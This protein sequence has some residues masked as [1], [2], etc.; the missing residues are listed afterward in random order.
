MYMK[1][2][3][4]VHTGYMLRLVS[5]EAGVWVVCVG[6][7]RVAVQGNWEDHGGRTR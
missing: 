1:C 5:G 3:L 7:R 6:G 2:T 4:N